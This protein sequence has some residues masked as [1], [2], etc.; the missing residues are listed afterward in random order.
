LGT[1]KRRQSSRIISKNINRKNDSEDDNDGSYDANTDQC[2]IVNNKNNCDD[3]HVNVKV[4]SNTTHDNND[5]I[6]DDNNGNNTD[7]D[8]LDDLKKNHNPVN[9]N[10]HLNYY[11]DKIKKKN[12]R[13]AVNSNKVEAKGSKRG[14]FLLESCWALCT[15]H[16]RTH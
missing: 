10:Y 14:G 7:T 4:T 9:D 3:V 16:H 1:R 2:D 8:K 13:A 5:G 15:L 11:Q 6:N 12:T